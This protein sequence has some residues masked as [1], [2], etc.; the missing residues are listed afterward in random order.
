LEQ[1]LD[2]RFAPLTP[3]ATV[4]VEFDDAPHIRLVTR[5]VDAAAHRLRIGESGRIVFLDLGYPVIQTGTI[6]PLLTLD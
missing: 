2:P 4:L 1:A 6:A 3:Y 5:L